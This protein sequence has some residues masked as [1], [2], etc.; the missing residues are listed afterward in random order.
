MKFLKFGLN[1]LGFAI[2][3]IS[4]LFIFI[5][6]AIYAVA[7]YA[8]QAFFELVSISGDVLSA[9][10]GSGAAT[11]VNGI[12]S[13]FMLLA[14]VYALFRLSIM[15]INYIINPD[16]V[17]EAGKEGIAIIKSVLFSVI[18]LLMSGLIFKELGEIQRIVIESNTISKIV[19]G[20]NYTPYTEDGSSEEKLKKDSDAFTN[21]VWS[22]FFTPSEINQTQ[23][24]AWESLRRAD[25]GFTILSMIGRNYTEFDYIPVVSGIVGLFLI[26]FFFKSAMQMAVRIFKLFALQIISPIPII[27]SA[28]PSQK[29]KLTTF[30]K[31]Y[32]GIYLEV[33]VRVASFYMAFVIL[34]VLLTA[35][36]LGPDDTVVVPFTGG[37][38]APPNL[39]LLVSNFVITIILIF[40]VFRAADEVPKVVEEAL[41]LKLGLGDGGN[42]SG[43]LKGLVGGTVAGV[44]GGVAAGTAASI[45]AETGWSVAGAAATGSVNAAIRGG[46]AASKAKGISGAIASVTNATKD[47]RNIGWGVSQTGN[48]HDYAIARA[49]NALG[50]GIKDQATL[51]EYDE[52]IK[53]IDKELESKDKEINSHNTEINNFTSQ[54]ETINRADQIRSNIE[55]I[56]DQDFE[57]EHGSFNDWIYRPEAG[58]LGLTYINTEQRIE[59]EKEQ[60]RVNN[61]PIDPVVWQQLQA[62]KEKAEKDLEKEYESQRVSHHSG[63]MQRYSTTG[64][65]G[66]DRMDA[67][68]I[69]Y[70]SFIGQNQSAFANISHELNSYNDLEKAKKSSN[71]Q[72]TQFNDSIA[73]ER[74]T[75]EDLK[76]SRK[77]IEVKKTDVETAKKNF[78]SQ[79]RVS[80][81][82]KIQHLPKGIPYS[83]QVAI[84]RGK[85]R[86]MGPRPGGPGPGPGG[87]RP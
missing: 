85:R 59:H 3:L 23:R 2:P 56:M 25:D 73:R 63:M 33:F 65:S 29:K 32:S 16:K 36:G 61:T 31:V 46:M 19:Y 24:S 26:F 5:D 78:A 70:G 30:I 11:L 45:G 68:M 37:A 21:S 57:N 62:D 51:E 64:S 4:E 15:A 43:V 38:I 44:A 71:V 35:A 14:G 69:S 54:I 50:M 42:F 8:L 7:S 52:Q 74:K 55:Q 1:I 53:N 86:P 49:G 41:S 9:T 47:S 79:N 12:I 81:R 87:P 82:E 66:N 10:S 83:D 34:Q 28:D 84:A 48:L 27:L 77:Q 60:A 22:L 80:D 75:I 76:L 58:N 72:I 39:G 6:W 13:R 18:L 20:T 17:R 40:A 67:S